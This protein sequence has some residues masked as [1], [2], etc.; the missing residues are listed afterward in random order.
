MSPVMY[1]SQN[2]HIEILQ[3]LIN[4]DANVNLTS[5]NGST[6]LMWAIRSGHEKIAELLLESGANPH[7]SE[8]EF[9]RSPLLLAA[10]FGRIGILKSLL[11]SGADI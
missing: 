6:A 3:K 8:N 10:K 2:G 4:R 7:P 1:A 5:L 11:F 9:Q